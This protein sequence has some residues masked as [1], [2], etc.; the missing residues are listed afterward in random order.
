MTVFTENNDQT[1]PLESLVGEDKKYKTAEELAKAYQHLDTFAENLKREQAEAREELGKRLT[2]EEQIAALA[3]QRRTEQPSAAP[4]PQAT[5]PPETAKPFTDEDLGNR[6]REVMNRD[7]AEQRAATNAQAV[8]DRLTTTFGTE[9]KANEFVN[10]KAKELGVSVNFLLDTAKTSPTG[11]YKLVD[12]QAEATPNTAT[13]S[14]VNTT[15]FAATGQIKPGTK[16]FYDNL[17]KT[18]LKLY[19]SPK[20]QNQMM[21]DALEKRGSFYT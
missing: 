21:K 14:E 8:V 13:R 6:I 4:A 18:D 12:I 20:I 19:M 3:N 15:N 7:N 17:R 11:F 1:N 16:A 10:A 2:V 9:A 5:T